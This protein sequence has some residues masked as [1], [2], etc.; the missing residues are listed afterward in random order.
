MNDNDNTATSAS[1]SRRILTY[2]KE[3]NTITARE[4]R[5]LFGCDRL[6]ARIADIEKILGY[7]PDR[8]RI[9]VKNRDD[10]QV[11]ICQYY[12]KNFV[13]LCLLQ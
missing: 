1:Q 13:D 3:G 11:Y 6:A 5:L 2:L 8:R 4:A 7:P 9:P 10:K 12:L